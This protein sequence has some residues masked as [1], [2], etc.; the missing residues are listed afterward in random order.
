[1]IKTSFINPLCAEFI[2]GYNTVAEGEKKE[3]EGRE[4]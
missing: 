3:E 4:K 1:M 2:C